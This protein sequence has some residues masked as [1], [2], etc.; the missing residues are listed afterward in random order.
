MRIS[1]E[2]TPQQG[3]RVL[4]ILASLGD[5]LDITTER[6]VTNLANEQPVSVNSLTNGGTE[7]KTSQP[8]K[9]TSQAT[10]PTLEDVKAEIFNASA[11][12]GTA[13]VVSEL[14]KLTGVRRAALVPEHQWQSVIDTMKGLL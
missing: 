4:A 5:S 8:A 2:L 3:E 1:I 12:V 11:R 9:P 13:R 14:I 10:L 6:N 7:V